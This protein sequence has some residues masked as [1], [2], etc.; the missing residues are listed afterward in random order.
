ML[1]IVLRLRIK[2]INFPFFVFH[3]GIFKRTND[4]QT[5]CWSYKQD[6][7]F[8]FFPILY[9]LVNNNVQFSQ[10][11]YCQVSLITSLSALIS[12]KLCRCLNNCHW[13]LPLHDICFSGLRNWW[14]KKQAS[15]T[16]ST[17]SAPTKP[18]FFPTGITVILSSIFSIKAINFTT[19]NPKNGRP[20]DLYAE[21]YRKSTNSPCTRQDVI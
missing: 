18:I 3:G 16:K 15:S 1:H 4:K 17:L 9:L 12:R 13:C 2:T 19:E 10:L 11:E 20:R 21:L 8:I 7:L 6:L 14:R 5:I